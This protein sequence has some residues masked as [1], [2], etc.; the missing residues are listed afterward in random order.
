[1]IALLFLLITLALVF[2]YVGWRKTGISLFF[3][4]LVW[5]CVMLFLLATTPL[6]INW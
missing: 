3:A 2:A 5:C 4:S 6:L 1:M